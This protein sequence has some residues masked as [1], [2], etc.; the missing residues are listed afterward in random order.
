[1][2]N[3][4]HNHIAD[5]VGMELNLPVGFIT[6]KIKSAKIYFYV[7]YS[8]KFWQGKY[9]QIGFIQKFDGKLLTDSLLD[10]WYLLYN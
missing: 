7:P 4:S 2:N 9:W 6:A 8:A 5:E 3:K 10:N 1:M